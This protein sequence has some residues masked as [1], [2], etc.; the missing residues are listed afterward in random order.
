MIIPNYRWKLV[1]YDGTEFTDLDGE[2]WES[3]EI[4]LVLVLQ[5]GQKYDILRDVNNYLYDEEF[6]CWV[7]FDDRGL[8]DQLTRDIRR[9]SCYRNGWWVPVKEE[10]TK[11]RDKYVLEVR[12]R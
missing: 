5:P 7:N 2:P 6:G 1:Y 4:G 10:W 8:F 9:Y 11:I 3:P 12:G